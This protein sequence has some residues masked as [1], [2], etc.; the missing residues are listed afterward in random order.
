M[1]GDPVGGDPLL[2]TLR[3]AAFALVIVAAALMPGP[4]RAAD[5]SQRRERRAT[6][7]EPVPSS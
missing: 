4:T 5:E 1:F 3:I 6:R 2:A 7:G